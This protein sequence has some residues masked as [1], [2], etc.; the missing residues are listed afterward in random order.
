GVLLSSSCCGGGAGSSPLFHLPAE[1]FH[2][3]AAA[4]PNSPGLSAVPTGRG[5]RLA[6]PASWASLRSPAANSRVP[7]D[8]QHPSHSESSLATGSSEGSL[9]TT[10]E[11][12]LSFSVSPPKDLHLPLPL[13]CPNPADSSCPPVEPV[14]PIEHPL[15]NPPAVFNLQATRGHQRS[16][17]SCGG[18]TSPGCNRQ[19]S[20][21]PSDEDL[22]IGIG[23]GGSSQACNSEHLSE[24]LSSLSLTSLLSPSSLGPLLVKKCNSTGSLDKGSMSARGKEGRR[25]YGMGPR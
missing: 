20:M 13:L 6:S 15:P 10:L 18:S 25:L 11:E 21:D 23:G 9:Q 5:S 17:S 1:F 19:D 16:Q 2:P 12:G 3:A 4:A 22:G 14:R 24:T 8:I 7:L